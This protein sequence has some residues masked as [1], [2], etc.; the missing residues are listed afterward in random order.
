MMA[1]LNDLG[2]LGVLSDCVQGRAA[3]CQQ[4]P[5]VWEVERKGEKMVR[6]SGYLFAP[7][8]VCLSL[9]VCLSVS[10]PPPRLR[11]R[12]ALASSSSLLTK[13]LHTLSSSQIPPCADSLIFLMN[14]C[15]QF[16]IWLRTERWVMALPLSSFARPSR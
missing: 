9:P 16:M 7:P 4:G 12:R 2:S 3:G 13:R 11:R 8:S 10:P 6:L 15:G 5:V 14:R 1:V